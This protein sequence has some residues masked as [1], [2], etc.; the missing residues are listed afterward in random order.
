MN[1]SHSPLGILYEVYLGYI[2]INN[3][4]GTVSNIGLHK[5][6]QSIWVSGHKNSSINSLYQARLKFNKHGSLRT[7]RTYELT[8]STEIL[9]LGWRLILTKTKQVGLAIAWTLPTSPG[10]KS[11]IEGIKRDLV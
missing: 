8:Q 4:D 3:A 7:S 10:D 1:V 5:Q 2:D 11:T 6:V 9:F